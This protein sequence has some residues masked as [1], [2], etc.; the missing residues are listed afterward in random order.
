[1]DWAERGGQLAFQ[2][3]ENPSEENVVTFMNLALF[4]YSQGVWRRSFIHKGSTGLVARTVT[5]C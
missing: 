2:E 4:W 1:M 5:G 3:V